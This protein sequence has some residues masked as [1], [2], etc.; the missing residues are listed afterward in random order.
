M[1]PAT[2]PSSPPPQSSDDTQPLTFEK[3][4]L[5]FQETDRKFQ[6]TDRKFQETQ[7][8][9][10][11]Q[12]KETDHKFQETQDQIRKTSREIEKIDRQFNSLW[13]KF[14]ESLVEGDL[15][16]L[17]NEKQIPVS[18]TYQQVSGRKNEIN[19][20]FD[21]IA[22]NG[23]EIVVVEV[24][25]TLKSDG[26]RHFLSKLHHIKDWI[27]EFAG[28]TIYGAVA[29][30][31]TE[32]NVIAHAERCGLFIIKATGNSANIINTNG[33]VPTTS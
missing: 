2:K 21:I 15:V 18:R 9:L 13:G 20:E 3:V 32:E 30:I 1:N 16:R 24:K 11:E 23:D 12:T 29:F 10:A 17:L 4:W 7:K 8:A 25:T 31:H 14:V 5:M 26:I 6:E 19:Y 22:A 33:F 27:P 28:K